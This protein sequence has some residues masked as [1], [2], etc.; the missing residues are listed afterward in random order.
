LLLSKRFR[1]GLARGAAH[2]RLAET[3]F[4]VLCACVAA[5]PDGLSQTGLVARLG[6]S[7]GQVSGLV[8]RLRQA[9]LLEARRSAADRR[10]QFWQVTSAG[11]QAAETVLNHL[12]TWASGIEASLNAGAAANLIAALDQ[13][14][15][16]IADGNSGPAVLAFCPPR[17]GAA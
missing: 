4:I 13:L 11:R 15:R 7:P 2:C 16:A 3:E 10:R 12:E 6:V 8:E 17:Q 14:A 9:G 1:D 5:E